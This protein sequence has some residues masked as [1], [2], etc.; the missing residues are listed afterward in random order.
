M[1]ETTAQ[2]PLKKE[3]KKKRIVRRLIA[4]LVIL[5]LLGGIGLYAVAR[6]QA[7]YTV[8][9]D[10]YRA[11]TGTISNS[12][13]F[14]GSLALK[15]SET[16]TASSSATVRNVYVADGDEVK[17]GD[18]LLRLSSGVTVTAGLDGRVNA[19]SVQKGDEV[20][21]GDTLLQVADFTHM[22]VSFRVDE[23]DISDVR[24]GTACTVSATAT[25]K[26]FRSQIGSINYISSSTGNV[27]YYTATA[28]VEADGGVYPGMQVTVSVP[29][30]EA[31]DVV[32][33]KQ[34]A[35]SFTAENTAFVYMMDGDGKLAEVPVEVGVSNGNYVEIKAGLADGDTVY[36]KSKQET[37]DSVASLF[38]GLFGGQRFNNNSQRQRNNNN[39]RN[40][41]MPGGFGGGSGGGR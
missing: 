28:D 10:D 41:T 15:D 16:H 3:K 39:N 38:S 20:K 5:V 18:K 11:T 37:A 27:A 9:Y 33:L 40:E 31:A 34:D 22:R 12:L 6:L 29:Q 17:K 1:S 13:S 26:T 23:Y 25:E 8:V 32:V 14:S 24:V 30:E 19:L 36:V 7:E 21:S 4:A 2:N 35:L